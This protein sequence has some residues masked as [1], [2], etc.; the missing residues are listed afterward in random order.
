M[1]IAIHYIFEY[2]QWNNKWRKILHGKKI[3]SPRKW[4][5]F[6]FFLQGILQNILKYNLQNADLFSC[7]VKIYSRNIIWIKENIY[8]KLWIFRCILHG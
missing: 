8:V 1:N 5:I 4:V 3:C 2:I 7:N 6:L